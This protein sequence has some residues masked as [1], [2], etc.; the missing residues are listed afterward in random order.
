M[1][2]LLEPVWSDS[3]SFSL[4]HFIS[5]LPSVLS[6][7]IAPSLGASSVNSYQITDTSSSSAVSC[8]CSIRASAA[9]K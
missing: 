3:K 5:V 7:L 2:P 1:M 6:S 8:K 4:S 9:R